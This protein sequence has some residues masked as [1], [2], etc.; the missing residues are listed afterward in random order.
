MTDFEDDGR[1]LRMYIATIFS[2]NFLIHGIV[3]LVD[4]DRI[5]ATIWASGA[6]IVLG[7]GLVAHR[8]LRAYEA[9]ARAR[10]RSRSRRPTTTSLIR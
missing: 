2:L 9:D 5:A 6:F 8:R 7:L 4:D 10:G 1:I 3:A